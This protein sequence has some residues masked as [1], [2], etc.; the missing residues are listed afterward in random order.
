MT[1][2]VTSRHFKAHQSLV[3]YAESAVE[4]LERYYD[5][6]IK[7]D[8]V[9]RYENARRSTKIAEIVVSVYRARLTAEERGDDF[10]KSIDGAVEK[11][12]VQL[13]RY[14]DKLHEKDRQEVRRIR[15]KI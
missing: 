14:K 6:I 11:I 13:K 2:N 12:L 5:G 15:E 10:F 3:D 7:G 1:I 9:L 8:V 4:R